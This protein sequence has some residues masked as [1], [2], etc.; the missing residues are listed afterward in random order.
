MSYYDSLRV[1]GRIISLIGWIGV[2]Y[3]LVTLYFLPFVEQPESFLQW[4]I[5]SDTVL[6][7]LTMFIPLGVTI[8]AGH[9]VSSLAIERRYRKENQIIGLVKAYGRINLDDLAVRMNMS[10]P[11]T[12]RK[13]ASLR[14]RRDIVF[15]IHD[16]YV[17]M[18]GSERKRPVKEIEK[19]TREIVTMQCTFCG[20]LIPATS[21]QCPECGAQPRLARV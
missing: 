20:S 16:G 2:A 5:T 21:K 18:P 15:S 7:T 10:V 13:L 1:G 8:W 14:A 4:I 19:I 17:V 6:G 3:F 9:R 12:E 11:E